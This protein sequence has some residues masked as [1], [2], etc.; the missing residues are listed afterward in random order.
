M[1]G[2]DSGRMP[3]AFCP[4]VEALL[5]HE[6]SIAPQMMIVRA[7]VLAR[8]RA[9]LCGGDW[10]LQP[11]TDHRRRLL[12]AA[13]AGVVLLASGA[14]AFQL[15]RSL[16]PVPPTGT[17]WPQVTRHAQLAPPSAVASPASSSAAKAAPARVTPTASTV[18][19]QTAEAGLP[20]SQL[21]EEDDVLDE[22]WLLERAQMSN[23]RGD[24]ATALAVAT[25]HERRYPAGRLCEEREVLRLRALVGLGRD[26]E[27]RQAVVRFRRDF[28]RSVLLP[29]LDEMV[30]ISR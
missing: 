30:A 4:G 5:A 21:G 22:L 11:A 3:P 9:A 2:D 17:P 7:R 25:D 18:S 12:F 1:R 20:K 16:P 23:A 19:A 27:A 10:V 26:G 6:R 8:A 24:F 13:A 15:A 14:A 29:K 28:P